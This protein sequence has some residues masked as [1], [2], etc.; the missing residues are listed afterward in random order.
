MSRGGSAAMGLVIIAAAFG[1]GWWFR[2]HYKP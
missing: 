2:G 1:A